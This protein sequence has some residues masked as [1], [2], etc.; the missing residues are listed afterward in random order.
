MR[1]T[2]QAILAAL[3]VFALAGCGTPPPKIQSQVNSA[4]DFRPFKT[5]TIL[6]YTEESMSGAGPGALLRVGQPVALE[7]QSNMQRL[8]YIPVGDLENADLAVNIRGNSIPKMQV[9]EYGYGGYYGAGGYPYGAGGWAGMY[10][11][12]GYGGYGMGVG[13][14][15]TVQVDQYN[16]GTLAIEVY[17]TKTK[18]LVWVGWATGRVE[19][20]G[21]D[22][23][24]L[25]AAIQQILARFPVATNVGPG[26]AIS[27]AP[28]N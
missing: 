9:T 24:R 17:E 28:A 22:M 13:M 11:Y 5:F 27:Q 20:D 15:S 10:P 23:D 6:P 25:R 4:I 8:G 19:T 2:K 26:N 21:P 12:G 16:E 3:S 7:I 14:G 18:E 1:L